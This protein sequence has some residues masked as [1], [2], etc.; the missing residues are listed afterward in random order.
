M[1]QRLQ[2]QVLLRAEVIA[3]HFGELLGDGLVD[4]PV[5]LRFPQRLHGFGQRVDEGVH[6]RGVEVVLLVPGGGR[7]HDVAVEAGG[8]HTEVEHGQQIELAFRRLLMKLHLGRANGIGL[9]AEHGVLRAEQVLEEVLVALA[10]GTENIRAPH[11]HIAREVLGVVRIVAAHIELARLQVLDRI[12]NRILAGGFGGGDD[13]ERIGFQLRRRRQPAHAFRL[14]VQVDQ[15]HVPVLDRIGGGRK[16][17]A[18]V[19]LFM[20][21]LA[22]VRVEET[23]AV[24]LAGRTRPVAGKGQRCPAEL[25]PQ[26]FLADVVGPAAAA[27]ADATAH[28]QHIDDAAVDHVIVV[29]VIQRG[30]DDDHALAVGAVGVVSEFAGDLNH[31]LALDRGVLFLPGRG[32]GHIVVVAAGDIAAAETAIHAVVGHLQVVDGG[33]VAVAAVS[34]LQLLR[35]HVADQ[36]IVLLATVVGEADADEVVL[37]IGQREQRIDFLARAAV[38]LFQI[39][40]TDLFAV[41]DLAF[42]PAETDAAVGRDDLAALLVDEQGLPLGVV[43]F[44]EIVGEMRSAQEVVGHQGAVAFLEHHQHG[45]VGVLLDVALEVARRCR[46]GGTP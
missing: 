44:A 19:Q 43:G 22:G 32:V 6:V 8:A 34:Q 46:R 28:H 31:Q 1:Q 38:L 39:P 42:A 27:L 14:G 30:A 9:V 24:H 4:L 29:P 23:G 37:V 11:E 21:P 45:H 20:A 25:R 40:A 13:I 26:L 41:I 5:G 18:H 7:Q 33:D 16:D 36:Q 17:L 3:A 12:G 15:A 10:A 35:G 2:H